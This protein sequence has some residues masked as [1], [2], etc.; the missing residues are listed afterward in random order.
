VHQRNAGLL[1]EAGQCRAQVGAFLGQRLHQ[2]GP[3]GIPVPVG[4]EVAADAV[5]ELLL[6]EEALEHLQHLPALLVDDAV[7]E[8]EDVRLGPQHG[9]DGVHPGELLAEHRPVDLLLVDE[10][11]AAVLEVGRGHLR[12]HEICE[13]LVEPQVVPP[14]HGHQIAEPLVGKLVGDVDHHVLP[15]RRGGSGRVHQ[16]RRLAV[17]DQAGVLHRPGLEVRNRH[18][19][20]LL[21][22][23]GKP[24]PLLEHHQQIRAGLHRVG[25]LGAA[26]VGGQSPDLEGVL[27][28]G[29]GGQRR[30]RHHVEVPH[31]EGHQVA[32][33]RRGGP[34][35]D[36]GEL[37]GCGTVELRSVGHR[38]CLAGDEEGEVP[39][40]LHPWLVEA[41]EGPPGIHRL[42]L[43][44]GVPAVA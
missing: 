44:E 4:L 41:G 39:G 18:V 2:I 5:A 15:L 38:H 17:G 1:D 11:V 20:Q 9:D 30:G 22:G 35:A 33:Q 36:P 37:A 21:V 12:L 24:E 16:E 7:V 6:A 27:T 13:R 28:D 23:E 8:A 42:E 10:V 43:G 32:G 25:E 26:A 14:G 34:E 40:N 31:R 3:G 19:V 29:V